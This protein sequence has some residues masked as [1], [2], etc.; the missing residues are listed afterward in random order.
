MVASRQST[1]VFELWAQ[2]ATF[3]MQHHFT[4][5]SN[6][7]T[8]YNYSDW[9]IWQTFSQKKKK[10]EIGLSLQGKQL[11]VFFATVKMQPFKGN[12]AFRTTCVC[13]CELDSI[14]ILEYFCD[15]TDGINIACV[16]SHVR[17]CVAPPGSSVCGIFQERIL[18]WV[19]ISFSRGSSRA[20]GHTCISFVSCIGRWAL[21]SWVPV[22]VSFLKMWYKQNM[23][24]F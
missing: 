10:K 16:L 11:T 9:G 17:L 8:N 23:K 18:E 19:A 13:N 3:F 22:N 24:I 20:R 14:P 6:W 15:E 21:L 1:C 12:L 7:Q 4:W 2:L 5:K